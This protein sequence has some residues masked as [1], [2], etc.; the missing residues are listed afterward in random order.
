MD[1]RAYEYRRKLLGEKHPDTMELRRDVL[2]DKH[3]DTLQAMH[4]LAVTWN[5]RQRH[6]EALATMQDCFQL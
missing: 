4:D 2:G 3:P 6:P 5:S 1:L